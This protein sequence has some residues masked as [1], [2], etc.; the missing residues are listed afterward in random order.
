M[1]LCDTFFDTGVLLPKRYSTG[2][3]YECNQEISSKDGIV[4][5]TI[6]E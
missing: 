6:L 2:A 1:M 5:D 4:C 3:T